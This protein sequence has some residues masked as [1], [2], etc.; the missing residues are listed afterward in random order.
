MRRALVIAAV[1]IFAACAAFASLIGWLEFKDDRLPTAGLDVTIPDG[2]SATSISHELQASGVIADATLLVLYYRMHG[3]GDRIQAA[4]YHFPAH[5]TV[6]GVAAILAAGGRQPSVWLTIPEGFT[7][8]QIGGR[9]ARVGLVTESSFVRIVHQRVLVF[10][11]VATAGL[12]GYLFPDTYQIPQRTT[13]EDVASLMT[14][15][16]TKE[17]PAD[18][19]AAARRLGFTV[20]QIVTIASMIEREAKV[21]AERSKIASVI[22]NRLRLGMTLEIDATIEYALP[23]HKTALSFADLALDSPYNT[24]KHTGLPPTPI[25]N[26]GKASLFAAFH[27]AV[28]PYLYYVYEGD[29]R[30]AFSTTLEQQQENERRYLR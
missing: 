8:E 20:P 10:G 29:G 28:T 16:F 23:K 3:G 13:A 7:A 27:P 21:D 15:Q 12:E 17:L 1:V 11:G 2:A 19:L 24:Y 14:A 26:P 22:Y 9:L 30:H 6:P 18:Y 25:S 5:M 4:I